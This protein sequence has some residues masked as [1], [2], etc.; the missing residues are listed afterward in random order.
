[1][2]S[3]V[4]HLP[5]LKNFIG[6]HGFELLVD[7]SMDRLGVGVA[8]TGKLIGCH[9]AIIIDRLSG[10]P[11][12]AYDI[13]NRVVAF[14]KHVNFHHLDN[15]GDGH[16]RDGIPAPLAFKCAWVFHLVIGTN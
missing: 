11:G 14:P 16:A 1:M 4:I 12:S 2:G 3:C 10:Y 15:F 8:D 7:E 5:E 6:G 13:L 9:P